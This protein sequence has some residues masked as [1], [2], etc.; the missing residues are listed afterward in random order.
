MPEQLELELRELGRDLSFPPEPDVAGR[1]AER[2]RAEP[3]P[4]RRRLR[5]RRRLVLALAALAVALAAAF[6]VP[7]VRAALFDLL[8][9]GGVTIERVE[10]LPPIT[11]SRTLG[12]GEPVSLAEARRSVDFPISV[13]DTAEWGRPDAVFLSRAVPGGRVSLLYGTERRVRLLVT[14]FRGDVEPG[15]VKK[16]LSR[17]TSLQ[18]VI[19]GRSAGYWLTGAP[20]AVVFRDRFGNIREDRYRLAGNVL[21]WVEDRVT[22]RIEG[23]EDLETALAIANGAR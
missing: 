11:P 2:L 6:A 10:E 20:H 18:G 12:L 16:A 17:E 13:P 22:H 21:L 19:V 1:V 7:P 14:E 23:V 9:I 8:G 15:L 3:E 5:T 4:L